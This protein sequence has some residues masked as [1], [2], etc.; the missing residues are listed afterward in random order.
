MLRDSR[1][2]LVPF[3][4][5]DVGGG[6]WRLKWNPNPELKDKLVAASM[7]GAFM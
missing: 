1:Q 3:A 5:H 7:R 6:V 2:T 4:E